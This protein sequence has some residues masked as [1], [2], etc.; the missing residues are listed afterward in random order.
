MQIQKVFAAGNSDVV[1]IPAEAKKKTGIKRGVAVVINISSD[2]QTILISKAKNKKENTPLT[3]EFFEWLENFNK[4][5]GS[6]LKELAK[7]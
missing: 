1:A 7:K 2:G 4:E 5:Y 3:P 6:A